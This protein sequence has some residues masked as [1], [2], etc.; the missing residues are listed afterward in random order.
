MW[1][2][3][4]L[5]RSFLVGPCSTSGGT[6]KTNGQTI[7]F[8]LFDSYPCAEAARIAAISAGFKSVASTRGR[9]I[10]G[11]TGSTAPSCGLR[12]RGANQVGH[13]SRTHEVVLS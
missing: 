5:G 3:T 11:F 9:S 2:A 8:D 7:R 13:G 12:S 1:V 10:Q 4:V 6:R